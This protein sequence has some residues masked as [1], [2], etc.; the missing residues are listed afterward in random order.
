MTTAEQAGPSFTLRGITLDCE[1]PQALAGFYRELLGATGTGDDSP[2]WVTISEPK[3]GVLIS[4]Q[5][6][7]HYRPP[8]WPPEE[9]GQQ[10][11]LH[12]DVQVDDLAAAAARAESLGATRMEFQPQDDVRVYADPAG[13]PFCLF[14]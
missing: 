10:M 2:D 12:F 4:F 1:D 8:I 11:M 14:V 6:A 7:R 5:R 9:Q 13:H 3:S